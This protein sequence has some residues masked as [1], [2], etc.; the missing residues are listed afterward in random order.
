MKAELKIYYGPC[1]EVVTGEMHVGNVSCILMLSGTEI[2][3]NISKETGEHRKQ[4]NRPRGE[5]GG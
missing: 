4:H 2:R 3:M 5:H 1:R